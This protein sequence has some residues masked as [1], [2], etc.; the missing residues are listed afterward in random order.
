MEECKMGDVEGDYVK[1]GCSRWKGV[2]NF[3]C[4]DGLDRKI[5]S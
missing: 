5:H 1:Y 4:V 3:V 2:D